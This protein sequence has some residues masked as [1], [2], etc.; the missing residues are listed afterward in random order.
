M[1]HNPTFAGKSSEYPL[2][3]LSGEVKEIL[4]QAIKDAGEAVVQPYYDWCLASMANDM[5]KGIDHIS[6]YN[7]WYFE[8]FNCFPNQSH[9]NVATYQ[10]QF[11]HI[12][13]FICDPYKYIIKFHF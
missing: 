7:K 10:F 8:I 4:K 5:T 11:I 13:I 3:L 2:N 12:D 9:T 1:D 6:H